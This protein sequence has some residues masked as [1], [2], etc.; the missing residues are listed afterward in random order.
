MRVSRIKAPSVTPI[1]KAQFQS[2]MRK[3]ST[4][5]TGFCRKNVGGFPAFLPAIPSRM[6]HMKHTK[7]MKHMR[8][9]KHM[10]FTG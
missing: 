8:Y 7:H 1:R 3:H 5:E 2:R 10:K 4:I 6:R 9:M